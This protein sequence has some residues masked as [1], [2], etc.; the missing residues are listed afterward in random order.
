MLRAHKCC[1]KCGTPPIMGS[2]AVQGGKYA[3][4]SP[5]Q[6][7]RPAAECPLAQN[8]GMTPLDAAENGKDLRHTECA[9][10]LKLFG[11]R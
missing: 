6:R 11:A 4:L 9:T 2:G 7:A 10:L 3:F 5:A 8:D 1:L